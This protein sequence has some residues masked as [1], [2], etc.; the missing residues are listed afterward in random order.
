MN[1]DYIMII[2]NV[3]KEKIESIINRKLKYSYEFEPFWKNKKCKIKET[4]NNI[5]CMYYGK[6]TWSNKNGFLG[7]I[8][9]SK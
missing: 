9:F 5:N 4:K 1:G 3:T 2:N 6:P 7:G 8:S